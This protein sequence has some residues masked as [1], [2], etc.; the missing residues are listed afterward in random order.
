M[1]EKLNI[2]LEAAN[3]TAIRGLNTMSN[4][5]KLNTAV[6]RTVH[7]HMQRVKEATVDFT[8]LYIR[9]NNVEVDRPS[10]ARILDI[11][12]EGLDSEHMN[13]LDTFMRELDGALAE[14]SEA[15]GD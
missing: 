1:M 10:L 7:A 14:F 15:D 5:D 3:N 13:K 12:S 2:C 4:R 8:Q 9:R 11:V 6:E